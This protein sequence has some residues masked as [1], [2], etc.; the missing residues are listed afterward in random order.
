MLLLLARSVTGTQGIA[1]ALL[2]SDWSQPE[3]ASLLLVDS[4]Y[5]QVSLI[6]GAIRP[7]SAR[8]E[9]LVSLYSTRNDFRNNKGRQ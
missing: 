7:N 1:A 9:A 4:L 6:P 2:G 8:L 5:L 3:P